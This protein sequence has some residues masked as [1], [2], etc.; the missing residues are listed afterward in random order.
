MLQVKCILVKGGENLNLYSEIINKVAREYKEFKNYKIN[1]N[2]EGLLL[3]FDVNNKYRDFNLTFLCREDNL[4]SDMIIKYSI[5]N[6]NNESETDSYIVVDKYDNKHIRIQSF[7]DDEVVNVLTISQRDSLENIV[8]N[9]SDY[10]GAII[11]TELKKTVKGLSMDNLVEAIL[12]YFGVRMGHLFSK[13]SKD[14]LKCDIEK[15]FL[16]K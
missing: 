7:T 16:S 12:E 3:D 14:I 8:Y 15:L 1:N 4:N 2:L 13:T 5:L 6:F 11:D 9:L 10:E